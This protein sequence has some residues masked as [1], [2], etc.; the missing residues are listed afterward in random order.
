MASRGQKMRAVFGSRRPFV[1]VRLLRRNE[2]G[3]VVAD[4]QADGPPAK[5]GRLKDA[6]ERIMGSGAGRLDAGEWAELFRD[7]TPADADRRWALLLRLAATPQGTEGGLRDQFVALP[8]GT[9]FS[10]RLLLIDGR[11]GGTGPGA[12]GFAQ[13]PHVVQIE[14]LK[15]ALSQ[16]SQEGRFRKDEELAGLLSEKAR[17]MGLKVDDGKAA[18]VSD[19]RKKLKNNGGRAM[20]PTEKERTQMHKAGR[21]PATVTEGAT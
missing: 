18:T 16:E 9:A 11:G 13:L 15:K 14:A 8:D 6:V 5:A 1:A 2:D 20:L 10:M 3:S 19:L 4:I 21:P 17:D 12:I 7:D